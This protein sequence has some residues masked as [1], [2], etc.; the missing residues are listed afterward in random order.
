M[1]Q[2]PLA[3]VFGGSG[4]IGRYIVH[5]LAAEGWRVRVAVRRPHT[6]YFLRALGE[7]GQVEPFQANVRDEKSIQRAVAG[8]NAVINLVGVLY[9]SGSQT[10]ASLQAEGA[11]RVASA[12]AKAG[13]NQFIQMS[14]IGADAASESAYARSKAEGE[15][16]VK[17]AFPAATILRPS[18]VFGPED[19]FFNRF[20]TLAR[21]SPILPLIS[22]GL[23]KFQPVYVGD[24]AKAAIAA[25]KSPLAAGRTFELGGPSVYTF[26]E[27]MQLMMSVTGGHSLLVPVPRPLAMWKAFFLQLL[28]KPLL[29][30]D[31]VRLLDHDNVVNPAAP[32]LAAL[33]IIATPAEAILP[34]YLAR[35]RKH[36]EFEPKS[37]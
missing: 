20:A 6:A 2:R 9:E 8:A 11:G 32:D 26:K 7:V 25:L 15:T 16:A 29:T 1:M 23:T 12:A 35:F 34:L 4:F 33:D 18:I 21:F 28:P 24:V 3:T 36:G 31:Q 19:D 13:V 14:A 10:F 17:A 22:G 30:V 37:A 5:A 27:L